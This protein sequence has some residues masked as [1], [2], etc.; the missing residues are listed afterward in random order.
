[1]TRRRSGTHWSR[2]RSL[3]ESNGSF[4]FTNEA[5]EQEIPPSAVV[6]H[7]LLL[8]LHWLAESQTENRPGGHAPNTIP[9]S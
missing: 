3:I 7:E 1:M 9:I 8:H 6:V 2:L 4:Y 5:A